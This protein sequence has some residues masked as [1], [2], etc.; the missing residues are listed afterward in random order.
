MELFTVKS[1]THT[2]FRQFFPSVIRPIL[3]FLAWFWTK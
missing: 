3:T 2:A 1:R